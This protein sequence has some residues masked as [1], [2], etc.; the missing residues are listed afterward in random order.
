MNKLN[1]QTFAIYCYKKMPDMNNSAL[2]HSVKPL[3]DSLDP[4]CKYGIALNKKYPGKGYTLSLRPFFTTTDLPIVYEWLKDSYVGQ[5]WKMKHSNHQVAEIYRTISRVNYAQSF[6]TLL[7]NRPVC[8]VDINEAWCDDVYSYVSTRKGDYI[9]RWLLPLTIKMHATLFVDI[10]RFCL[11]YFFSFSEVENIFTETDADQAKT[12]EL[13]LKTGFEF[14]RTID[15]PPCKM[16]IYCYSRKNWLT[17]L[18]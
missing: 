17:T 7:D 5:F 6:L 14:S 9:I 3:C 11:D 13:M 15:L 4:F 2:V 1:L 10:I 12:N 16:N 18:L 8:Q